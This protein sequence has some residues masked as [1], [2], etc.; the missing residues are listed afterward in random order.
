[1]KNALTNSHNQR[2]LDHRGFVKIYIDAPQEIKKQVRQG[3][4]DIADIQEETDKD[5]LKKKASERPKTIFIPNF[6]ERMKQFNKDVNKL[7]RQ[8]E[9]FGKIFHSDDFK[10]RYSILGEKQKTTLT[11][12]ITSIKGRIKDCYDEVEYF[13]GQLPLDENIIML[14]ER[15]DNKYEVKVT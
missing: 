2:V 8:I 1:M 10:K 11:S 14:E 7:E 5:F 12:V 3:T 13:S 9:I 15:N 6:A 4:L